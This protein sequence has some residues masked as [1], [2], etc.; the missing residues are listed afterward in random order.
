MLE[1]KSKFV[2]RIIVAKNG[3]Y[4]DLEDR[5]YV[6]VSAE[7]KAYMGRTIGETINGI[8]TTFGMF[9]H[10]V[11]LQDN[12]AVVSLYRAMLDKIGK[13]NLL[14]TLDQLCEDA[15]TDTICFLDGGLDDRFNYRYILADYFSD[16]LQIF[17]L[18]SKGE[19]IELDD[20]F[21][22]AQ[23]DLW[24]IDVCKKY[25]HDGITD[26]YAYE[27]LEKGKWSFAKT[28]ANNPHYY[29]LRKDSD[30][31]DLYKSLVR[32][33]RYF[34]EFEVFAGVVY[35]VWRYKGF[36]Y[37]TMPQEEQYYLSDDDCYL[38]NKKVISDD[39]SNTRSSKQE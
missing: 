22:K 35:R 31:W 26:E 27:E 25:G 7:G 17:R 9:L 15:D 39:S 29:Y 24:S 11:R 1:K 4:S 33:I 36:A 16:C 12:V 2:K 32:H 14:K 38:I 13:D 18:G 19:E 34:G 30:D 23:K 28:M 6:C 21:W 37:W 20:E 10:K 8:Q 3:Y 5:G